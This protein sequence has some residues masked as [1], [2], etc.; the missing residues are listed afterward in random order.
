MNEEQRNN[1]EEENGEKKPFEDLTEEE[2]K[3]LS[4]QL[5]KLVQTDKDLKKRRSQAL[6][7]H[8][9]LHPKFGIHVSVQWLINFF[10]LSAVIGL[11]NYGVIN[12]FYLYI[13]GVSLFTILEIFIKLFLFK[14][15]QKVVIKSYNSIHVFYIVPIL[16]L[17]IELLGSVSFNLFYERL[18]VLL[19]FLALRFF[20]SYY[21]KLIFYSR[22]KQK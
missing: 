9:A 4:D 11:T 1:K 7:F 8:Y 12:N 5:R 10:V 22:R 18:I 13:L 3:Q 17:S 20:A 16:Y 14:F 21:I 19:S 15:L 6:F 2:L